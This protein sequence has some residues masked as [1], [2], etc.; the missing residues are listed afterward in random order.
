MGS[1]L[2]P[3]HESNQG[4]LKITLWKCTGSSMQMKRQCIYSLLLNLWLFQ[5]AIIT[6][7]LFRLLLWAHAQI[8][9]HAAAAAAASCNFTVGSRSVYYWGWPA[10]VFHDTFSGVQVRDGETAC[11]SLL[12][13]L[14]CC[15]TLGG[16]TGTPV[17][18][19]RQA[20]GWCPSCSI[21]VWSGSACHSS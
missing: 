2:K 7:T 11:F 10:H 1:F 8:S 17:S 16:Q 12:L 18:E 9:L 21:D 14:H 6:A 15:F 5:S 20:C 3:L 4:K 13:T 19:T